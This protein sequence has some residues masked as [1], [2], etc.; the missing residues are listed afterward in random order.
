MYACISVQFH[1]SDIPMQS[2]AFDICRRR[3]MRKSSA[4][5]EKSFFFSLYTSNWRA[6]SKLLSI[7]QSRSEQQHT[8]VISSLTQRKR[9][10]KLRLVK[11][12]VWAKKRRT[13]SPERI[14]TSPTTVAM[15]VWL[16]RMGTRMWMGLAWKNFTSTTHHRAKT[17][18]FLLA[19]NCKAYAC[20]IT[21]HIILSIVTPEWLQFI[22]QI[23]IV[24]I[25]LHTYTHITAVGYGRAV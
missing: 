16:R 10:L 23:I 5:K 15:P 14:S 9:P 1:V 4:T 22:I 11:L 19:E 24:Y 7:I 18:Q 25:T 13:P 21:C 3:L 17:N 20:I 8:T 12:Q 2:M 6:M